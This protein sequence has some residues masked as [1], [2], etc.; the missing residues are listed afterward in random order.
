ME[1]QTFADRHMRDKLELPQ[2]IAPHL[3]ITGDNT[4]LSSPL[5]YTLYM[6][7]AQNWKKVLVV[8]GN[9]EY[10]RLNPTYPLS[11][12]EHDALFTTMFSKINSIVGSDVLI[13]LQNNVYDFPGTD[14]RF[15][16]LTYWPK[17]YSYKQL[18]VTTEILRNDLFVT[19]DSDTLYM[20]QVP[21]IPIGWPTQVPDTL[22]SIPYP[23]SYTDFSVIQQFYSTSKRG[24][25]ESDYK[26]M[27]SD[28]DSFLDSA[29]NTTRRCV[30]VT[31]CAPIRDLQLMTTNE[32]NAVEYFT[33]DGESRFNPPL[34]AWVC[35][36]V[37]IPQTVY[38]NLIPLYVNINLLKL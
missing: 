1:F 36:H 2:P 26:T 16:G 9:Q 24:M 3:I 13:L 37:H 14:L 33:R 27:Q 10:E 8:L 34:T 17:L 11:M 25:T 31:H 5:T 35:G 29:M 38:V 4:F 6:H 19:L 28:E 23:Y 20:R 21:N 30:V 15:I 12:K 22:H 32:A 18:Y 7:C